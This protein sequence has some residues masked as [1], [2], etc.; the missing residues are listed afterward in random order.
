MKTLIYELF[1]GVGFCNQVFSLETAIYLANITNRKLILLIRFPL[2]HVGQSSWEYGKLLNFFNDDYLAYL[3]NGIETHYGAV[4]NHVTN[5]IKN[6]SKCTTIKFTNIFSQIGIIDPALDIP[7]NDKKINEFLNHRKKCV[8][9]FNSFSSEYIYIDK[10]N[11]SRCFYNFF[12]TNDNYA[13]MSRICESLTHLQPSFYDIITRIEELPKNY[14]AIH[15]RFGDRKY[16]KRDVDR[17]SNK[18]AEPLFKLIGQLN[19][20]NLP[21]LIMC[22]RRDAELLVRLDAN[23]K[24]VFVSNLL[25]DVD[26]NDNF[27]NFTRTEVI[28]FLIQKHICEKADYFIGHDGSTV[29]HYINYIQYLNDKPY[30]YYLDKVLKYNYMD[31]TWKL[32]GFVG[33]NISFRVFFADNVIKPNVKLITLTN[34]GYMQFTENLLISMKKLGIETKLK[35]Y[36]IG[37]K[38]YKFFNE[39]FTQ[40]EVEHI[41]TN[42]DFLKTWVEYKAAQNPD[43]EGK[44][45]WASITSYKMYAIHNELMQ[46][47]DVIFTDGDIVF[48]KDPISYMASEIK[49]N[50]LLIQNDNQNVSSKCMCTGIMYMKSNEL[51]KSITNFENITENIESFTNDQQYLRRFE[52]SMKVEYLDLNLFPNGLFYRQSKPSSPYMIHFNYDVSE[53]KI[54]RMKTFGKWYLN[55]TPST[56]TTKA[57]NMLSPLKLTSSVNDIQRS[58]NRPAVPQMEKYVTDLPLT[59]YVESFGHKIRQGYI[60]QLPTHKTNLLS[61]LDMNAKYVLEVGFLAGHSAEMFLKMNKTVNVTSV[62]IGAFQ[63]VD[64]GKKYIDINY[65]N[66]HTLI[67]GNSTQILPKLVNTI[68]Y[69]IIFIDGSY[70][71]EVVLSD[72]WSCK[73]LAH[74]NTNLIINNVLSN[75]H[76]IKYWNKGPTNAFKKLLVNKTLK[77]PKFLDIDLGKGSII[78]KYT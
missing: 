32:N 1:S 38:S 74:P 8:L 47:N 46:D 45:R 51:T 77:E 48:E 9:D 70:E 3:P 52:K 41:D 39:N 69:D 63:S 10:S 44:K 29:S 43:V 13:T 56:L 68:K 54:K 40:N 22:D 7:E 20:S 4:P 16:T 6:A 75:E 24:V 53:Q 78:C 72:I 25:K 42:E 15:F 50:D 27:E 67:K 49:N 73:Q 58:T 30:Y 21:I 26:L 65:P 34:D 28:D 23:F 71:E 17:N 64:C 76:W 18:F 59:K 11:A 19:S 2:C 5:T 36:C 35:I 66:R 60:T 55:D 12:T 14:L 61:V 37:E 57:N 31:Y 33:G 62:D